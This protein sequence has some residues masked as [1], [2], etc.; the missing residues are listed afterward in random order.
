MRKLRECRSM[1]KTGNVRGWKDEEEVRKGIK[2][3]ETKVE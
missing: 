2:K 1:I 3:K